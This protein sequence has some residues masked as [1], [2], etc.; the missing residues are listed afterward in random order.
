[1]EAKHEDASIGGGCIGDG[2]VISINI[3]SRHRLGKEQPEY[4]AGIRDD[5]SAMERI[6]GSARQS[7][8]GSCRRAGF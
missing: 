5:C 4:R 3:C 8:T 6:V 7:E 2:L 1:M